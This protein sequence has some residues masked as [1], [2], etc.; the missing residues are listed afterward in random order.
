M[1]LLASIPSS[2]CFCS[3]FSVPSPL[4]AWDNVYGQNAEFV[5][6]TGWGATG[7]AL[8]IASI[9][10]LTEFKSKDAARNSH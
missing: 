7:A 5:R 9:A 6:K 2:V 1:C 8:A 4:Q 3:S 10:A